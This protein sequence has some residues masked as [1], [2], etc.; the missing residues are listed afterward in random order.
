MPYGGAVRHIGRMTS[1][2]MSWLAAA[3]LLAM[4]LVVLSVGAHAS[5][6]GRCAPLEPS[7]GTSWRTDAVRSAGC[8][9]WLRLHHHHRWLRS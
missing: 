1:A 6:S 2:R 7:Y 5:A 8:H 4:V 9:A 3:A